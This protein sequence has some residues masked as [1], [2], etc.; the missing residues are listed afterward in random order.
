MP[1]FVF[2]TK[3]NKLV[4][5]EEYLWDKYKDV[6]DKQAVIGNQ[7]VTMNYISDTMDATRHM[8]DGKYYTSK[9]AFRE[10]T[11]RAGCIEIGNETK[12]LTKRREPKKLDRR[13][14]REDIKKAIHDLRNG[15]TPRIPS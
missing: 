5:K 12:Y 13:Q 2:D 11:K 3:Q 1:S 10:A 14:R 8:A 6:V 15:K 9:K 7:P 4:P